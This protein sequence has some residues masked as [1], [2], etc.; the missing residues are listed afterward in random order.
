M[1]KPESQEQSI[2]EAA[3][4]R[5]VHYGYGKTTM[6]E[7]ARD[8]G[9]S[10][11]NIYR[12]FPGKLDI[13]EAIARN[14]ADETLLRLK[15]ALEVS[16]LSPEQKIRLYLFEAL[17]STYQRLEHDERI[18]EMAEHITR[19]RPS[20]ANE[21]LA[22][23]REVVISLLQ[24]GIDQ[25]TFRIDDVAFTAEMIQSA[26]LKFKYPQLFSRL[27]LDELERE[28]AGVFQLLLAGLCHGGAVPGHQPPDSV[29][30]YSTEWT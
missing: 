18:F 24:E 20:F 23:E 26:T 19:E 25:G 16:D 1:T 30:D 13:A 17:R 12:F 28:L 15:E 7:I 11:G 8:C 22:K 2:V 29:L 9:M 6:A 5:F 4:L 27:K 21:Q 3:K 10:P 14:V